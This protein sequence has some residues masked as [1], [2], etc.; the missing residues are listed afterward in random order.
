MTGFPVK[1]RATVHHRAAGM[2]E[3]CGTAR[4]TEIHHRR[5][6][7]MGGSKVDDTNTASNALFLCA[8]CHGIIEDQRR[9]AIDQGWLV[10]QHH[11][12]ADI[13]VLYRGAWVFLDDLGNMK[14]V[15]DVI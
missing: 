9:Y 4:A 8:R 10:K 3:K 7:G 15:K 12:P 5:P 6:R 1:V 13:P 2:C 11:H 14:P